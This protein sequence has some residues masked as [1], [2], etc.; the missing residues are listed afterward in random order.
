M[1]GPDASS[2]QDLMPGLAL[3]LFSKC[4]I[5]GVRRDGHRFSGRRRE[6]AGHA[7]KSQPVCHNTRAPEWAPFQKTTARLMRENMRSR[8]AILASIMACM[9]HN[10]SCRELKLILRHPAAQFAELRS[11]WTSCMSNRICICWDASLPLFFNSVGTG[12]THAT[13][14]TGQSARKLEEDADT[15]VHATVDK[16]LAQSIIQARLAKKLNQKELATLIME[17]PTVIQE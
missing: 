4:A 15:F 8:R 12:N 13:S 1:R 10:S 17:K 9:R 2:S 14:G 3:Q 6:V 5:M 16:N 7:E 11:Y